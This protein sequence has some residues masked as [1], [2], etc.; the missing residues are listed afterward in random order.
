MIPFRP[1]EEL[2]P[3]SE[4]E[5]AKYLES[6]KASKADILLF[7]DKADIPFPKNMSR[8][9]LIAAAAKDISMTGVFIRIA[10]HHK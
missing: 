10:N 5:V 9:R 2:F 1:I 6:T 3:L 8:T 4:A 7:L